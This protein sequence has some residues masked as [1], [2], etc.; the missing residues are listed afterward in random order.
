MGY[1]LLVSAVLVVLLAKNARADETTARPKTPV[2]ASEEPS[3][4]A[5]LEPISQAQKDQIRGQVVPGLASYSARLASALATARSYLAFYRIGCIGTINR[6]PNGTF[7][8]TLP[9]GCGT[10]P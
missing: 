10:P 2:C 5:L 3:D 6:A 7:F 4:F 9:P 1:V 8:L